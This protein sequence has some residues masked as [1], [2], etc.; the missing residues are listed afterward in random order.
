[1]MFWVGFGL[2]ASAAVVACFTWWMWSF[3]RDWE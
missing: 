2:G 1:M 3:I